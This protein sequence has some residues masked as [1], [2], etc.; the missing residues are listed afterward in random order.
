MFLSEVP[1]KSKLSR[2]ELDKKAKFNK[3]K[4]IR[5]LNSLVN[6]IEKVGNGRGVTYRLNE[7]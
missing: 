3:A 1:C 5:I 6:I 2:A 4:S 7:S